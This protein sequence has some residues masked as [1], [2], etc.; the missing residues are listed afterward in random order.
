[1][2]RVP[3]RRCVAHGLSIGAALAAGLAAQHEGVHC[4]LDQAFS[5][6]AATA[7]HVATTKLSVGEMG[8]LPAWAISGVAEAC[9][10]AGLSTADL[11]AD[12]TAVPITPLRMAGPTKEKSLSEE[13][14]SSHSTVSLSSHGSSAASSP[15]ASDAEATGSGGGGGGGGRSAT[16]PPRGGGL[17]RA[18]SADSVGSS[19]SNGS[20][21]GGSGSGGGSGHYVTDGFD[22]VAKLRC[23]RRRARDSA[24]LR[25]TMT[26]PGHA[27]AHVPPPHTSFAPPPLSPPMLS[28]PVGPPAQQLTPQ[29]PLGSPPPPP[30]PPSLRSPAA[31]ECGQVFLFAASADEMVPPAFTNALLKARYG[32]DTDSDEDDDD[33]DK[34][35]EEASD[36]D[37][38]ARCGDGES[39]AG[40]GAGGVDE[41]RGFFGWFR[42]TPAKS[43]PAEAEAAAAARAAEG[44]LAVARPMLLPGGGAPDAVTANNSA[45]G[46]AGR[47]VGL[48]ADVGVGDVGVLRSLAMW[49]LCSDDKPAA[50]RPGPAERA[51]R[52]QAKRARKAA[53]AASLAEARRTRV[54]VVVGPHGSFFGSDRRAASCFEN[55]LRDAGFIEFDDE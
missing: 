6:G 9:L 10:P 28:P 32:E 39:G 51:A 30:P 46:G 50:L 55:F 29:T 5:S 24:L 18:E 4:V 53:A 45:A 33:D 2:Q 36:G 47:E 49:I 15:S 16:P 42:R 21:G 44:V 3:K 26:Q 54:G 8:L 7:H 40:G 37:G 52:R 23:M 41:P 17:V 48:M 34:E 38:S 43:G 12:P 35:E 22:N 11:T 20:G 19:T 14:S 1:V 25:L 27:T 13:S 31:M